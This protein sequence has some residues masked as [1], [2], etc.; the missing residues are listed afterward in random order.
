MGLINNYNTVWDEEI[1]KIL[2]SRRYRHKKHLTNK[3]LN[4]YF[5]IRKI[6]TATF[7]I[8]IK[9]KRS[10]K[11]LKYFLTEKRSYQWTTRHTF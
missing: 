7:Q 11:G 4:L 8:R 10:P 1:L 3:H 6:T 2:K 5:K 9:K